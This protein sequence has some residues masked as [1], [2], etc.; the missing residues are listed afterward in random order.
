MN[1]DAKIRLFSLLSDSLDKLTN[2]MLRADHRVVTYIEIFTKHLIMKEKILN[3]ASHLQFWIIG[4]YDSFSWCTEC[5]SISPEK[6]KQINGTVRRVNLLLKSIFGKIS[7][8]LLR[9]S[10]QLWRWR[11]GP[12]VPTFQGNL[13]IRRCVLTTEQIEAHKLKKNGP[14]KTHIQDTRFSRRLSCLAIFSM[15]NGNRP[16]KTNM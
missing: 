16:N 6:K 10:R 13:S 3:L 7:F 4:K 2:G 15:T 14:N 8:C 11:I 12:E 5:V 9:I 1:I